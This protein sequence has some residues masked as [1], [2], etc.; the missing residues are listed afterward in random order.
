MKFVHGDLARYVPKTHG[1]PSWVVK[2]VDVDTWR[3]DRV[4]KTVYRVNYM[5]P[6]FDPH[7]VEEVFLRPLSPLERLALEAE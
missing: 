7:W 2:I 4:W 1:D 3:F 6:C 5:T